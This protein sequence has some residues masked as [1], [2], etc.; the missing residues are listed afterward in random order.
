MPKRFST[1]QDGQ[2]RRERRPR[3]EAEIV[4][5]RM[6][7]PSSVMEP[8][9]AVTEAPAATTRPD[10]KTKVPA[11]TNE[12]VEAIVAVELGSVTRKVSL[13]PVATTVPISLISA[14]GAT[15]T[16]PS[17]VAPVRHCSVLLPSMS[18]LSAS[19]PV[20]ATWMR[21]NQ[22]K[23]RGRDSGAFKINVRLKEGPSVQR[24]AGTRVKHNPT[25]NTRGDETH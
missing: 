4:V 8:A 17:T 1:G 21:P 5:V 15:R 14:S 24:M 11:D 22:A 3:V 12:L 6:V 25:R 2:K 16:I 19:T 23:G 18:P 20:P 7:Q 10:P 9:G 13:P